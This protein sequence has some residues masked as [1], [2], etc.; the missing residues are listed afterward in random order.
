MKY[1][2]DNN[3]E[4]ITILDSLNSSRWNDSDEWLKL[5]CFFLNENLPIDIFNEYNKK[6]S[7]KYDETLNKKL[8][9]H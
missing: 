9:L 8:Y 7:N 2:T 5:Y 1:K 6:H 4:L 3:D